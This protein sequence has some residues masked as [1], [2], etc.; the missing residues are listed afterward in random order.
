MRSHCGHMPY[1]WQ[2]TLSIV[3][4]MLLV[5]GASMSPALSTILL[6]LVPH[7]A[8][9]DCIIN[10]AVLELER[11]AVLAPSLSLSAEIVREADARRRAFLGG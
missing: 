3:A 7:R 4:Q 9:L 8:A 6:S 2:S 10:D 5:M 11:Y 1:L